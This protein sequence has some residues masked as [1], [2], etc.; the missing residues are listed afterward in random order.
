[1]R[2]W[3]VFEKL[4]KNSEFKKVYKF[5]KSKANRYLVMILVERVVPTAMDFLSAR[6]LEIA[7]CVIESPGYFVNPFERMTQ[8]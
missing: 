7:L 8:N 2:I 3:T 6:K 4:G 5:G 1:M